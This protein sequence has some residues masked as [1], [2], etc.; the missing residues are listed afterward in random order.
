MTTDAHAFSDRSE[1]RSLLRRRSWRSLPPQPARFSAAVRCGRSYILPSMPMVPTS[2]W[3][4]KAATTRRAW[5][6]SASDGREAFVDGRD[7]VG[8]DGDP[9]GEAVAPRARQFP[10]GPRVPVVGPYNVSSGATPAAAAANRHCA[11]RPDRV[12]STRRRS[13]WIAPRARRRGPRPP[14]SWRRAA[15]GPA[16]SCRAGTSPWRLGRDHHHLHLRRRH[17]GGDLEHIDVVRDSSRSC[18]AVDLRKQ[19]AIETRAGPPPR[20]RRASARAER[21]DADQ[22]AQSRGGPPSKPPP[23]RARPAFVGGATESSRS[24]ISAS[25]P[26]PRPWRTC[27][28]CRPARTAASA[29]SCRTPQHQSGA[30]AMRRLPRRAD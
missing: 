4:A 17:A 11:R 21:I 18:D 9:A 10:P 6:T 28:R 30:E 23:D 22:N 27:A 26:M 5:A 16:R 2:G 19:D 3:A 13:C 14:R 24:R 7:L 29:A 1:V 20:D 15:G 8:M 12:R 25:A